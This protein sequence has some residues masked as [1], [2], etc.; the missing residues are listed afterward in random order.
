MSTEEQA[1]G[2]GETF[3]IFLSLT[4][5]YFFMEDQ[6]ARR[7][8]WWQCTAL[9]LCLV[10]R[11]GIFIMLSFGV[12]EFSTG[13]TERDHEKFWSGFLGFAVCLIVGAPLVAYTQAK[14][15]QF[16][17]HWKQWTMQRLLEKYFRH[18]AFYHLPLAG[19]DN[20]D[21]RLTSDVE[22][23]VD[24]ACLFLMEVTSKLMEGVAFCGVLWAISPALVIALVV[25]SV[26][27]TLVT[28]GLFGSSLQRLSLRR[29]AA[30]GNLRYS[31]VRVRENVES[32]AFYAAAA[33]PSHGAES[34]APGEPAAT[35]R[36]SYAT[37]EAEVV[38]ARLAELIR[39]SVSHIMAS[40]TLGIWRNL[41]EFS[42]L[43][44]PGLVLAP[45]YFAG[46]LDFGA[47]GQSG[48][49]FEALRNVGGLLV[50][51]YG[52]VADFSST[53]KRLQA[54]EHAMAALSKLDVLADVLPSA[55]DG[56]ASTLLLAS[57]VD[58]RPHVEGAGVLVLALELAVRRG[59]RM[60]IM[61]PSGVGKSSLLRV[62][63]GLWRT[64]G[65]VAHTASTFFLP[66]RPYMVLGSLM[67][68][69]GYP[70]LTATLSPA[71]AED[72]LQRVGLA[73]LVPFLRGPKANE[74]PDWPSVLSLGEQQRLAL[75]RL[76]IHS[77]QL[78]LLDE[79]S[80]ALDETNEALM[81]RLLLQTCDAVVS[82]GHRSS[83]LA[84]H[85][86]VLLLSGEGRWRLLSAR[87]YEA[88]VHKPAS[89]LRSCLRCSGTRTAEW[90]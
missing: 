23:F 41:Y 63:A 34:A 37:C 16:A 11:T 3:R 18:N 88:E 65:A 64:S 45:R 62:I 90:K 29:A 89:V 46:E 61:G 43:V 56:G 12:R 83:L 32:I 35:P 24:K 44:V 82:V 13:L 87:A 54:L 27:G 67:E 33:Q 9:V 15:E 84:F 59:D 30:S 81:Y 14:S 7:A 50:D 8:L 1:V 10:A 60:L 28:Q 73:K 38:S 86:H 55:T 72:A 71:V 26:V 47:I 78:A 70:H 57:A 53:C 25:Y 76:L 40:R 80:S 19:I 79:A 42:A 66:Q 31:L 5:P 69:L 22:E 36:H 58:V 2:L 6:R 52:M 75:A 4:R 39:A 20:P 49:A 51:S 85:T 21:Q 77:P 48:G 17:L 74:A 68:Q